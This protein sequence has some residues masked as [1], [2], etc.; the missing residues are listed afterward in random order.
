[1]DLWRKDGPT[2]APKGLRPSYLR[3]GAGARENCWGEIFHKW[4]T[5]ARRRRLR[6]TVRNAVADCLA[7]TTQ[8][9]F[10]PRCASFRGRRRERHSRRR[11]ART[12]W[13]GSS[14][15]ARCPCNFSPNHRTGFPR[16][17][18]RKGKSKASRTQIDAEP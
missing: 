3:I 5:V 1:M 8:A 17:V 11:P 18:L 14:F 10:P 4:T 7:K 6:L 15:Q 16:R 2:C 9:R 13:S 12:A